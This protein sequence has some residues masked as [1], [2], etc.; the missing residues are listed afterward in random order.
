[1]L[2]PTIQTG[3]F[4]ATKTTLPHTSWDLPKAKGAISFSS[5]PPRGQSIFKAMAWV[6]KR[7]C[8]ILLLLLIVIGLGS[9]WN[10]VIGDGS[11][12]RLSTLQHFSPMQVKLAQYNS[13]G[14]LPVS[15]I[16][17]AYWEALSPSRSL[18][19]SISPQLS[20]WLLDLHLRQHIKVQEPEDIYQT[21]HV[22]SSETLLAAYRY[23]EDTLY[24]GEAFW[25][26][27]D[28]QKVT[29]LA[30][31]YRHSRQNFG[32]RMSVQLA[33]WMG[34]GQLQAYSPLEDEARD[35]ERQAAIALGIQ[36]L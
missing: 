25:Q 24:L 15:T 4:P 23:N 29:V 22:A 1:M 6:I 7:L 35:Y 13:T 32:K 26:L 31:E 14:N 36:P 3:P 2:S 34:L 20:Q 16:R 5:V 8:N 27:S 21:Y 19:L 28:G 18:L 11:L 33:Q 10:A 9:V 17:S 12:P 30:H